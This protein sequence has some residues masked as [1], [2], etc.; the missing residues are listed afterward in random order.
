VQA[1]VSLEN[2]VARMVD[3]VGE[4][5][6]PPTILVNNA[7]TS[8][9]GDTP[10]CGIPPSN[11]DRVFRVNVTGNFLCARAVYPA[12]REA[13]N[14]AIVNV[15][16]VRAVVGTTGNLHYSAS[17][18]AQLGLTRGLAAEVAA[19]GIRVNAVIVGAIKTPDEAFYGSPEEVDARVVA[20][21]MLQRR[22]VPADVA[23][24]VSFLCS[25]DASFV[26]GQTLV[27]DGGMVAL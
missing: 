9:V 14:G 23:G 17:K 25:D 10:W 16:S 20:A 13:E 5:L 15:S 2:E 24:L 1:D 22:G 26:T 21:Q 7:A 27:V 4:R 8:V 12:M 3:S 11:W 6:G 18:A 19:D